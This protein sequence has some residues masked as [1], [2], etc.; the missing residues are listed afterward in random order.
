[1]SSLAEWHYRRSF[2]PR[3]T[4]NFFGRV[5]GFGSCYRCHDTWNHTKEHCTYF[6]GGRGCFPLCERCWGAL[7]PYERL[8]YYKQLHQRWLDQLPGN[9]QRRSEL[10]NEWPLIRRAVMKGR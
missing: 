7:Q 6:N 9:Q 1:V 5:Q 10:I 3:R 8:P 4:R 2:I